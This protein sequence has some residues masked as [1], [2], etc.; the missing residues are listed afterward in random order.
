[1]HIPQ[2]SSDIDIHNRLNRAMQF[3]EDRYSQ[4]GLIPNDHTYQIIMRML[5]RA[6]RLQAAIDL[7]EKMKDKG[8]SIYIGS[9]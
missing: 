2:P 5:T 1:M 6:T 4:H 3:V 8:V 7:L 9:S